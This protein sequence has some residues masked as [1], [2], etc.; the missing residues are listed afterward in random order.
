MPRIK[1]YKGNRAIIPVDTARVSTAYRCPF[2][3]AI[4]STKRQY[5]SHLKDLRKDKMH[6]AA[7]KARRRRLRNEFNNQPT[8]EKVIEWANNHPEFFF[9]NAAIHDPF[10]RLHKN[11]AQDRLEFEFEI[12]K[13]NLR[14]HPHVSNSHAA[15]YNGVKN[16][17]GRD[18]TLPT[19][20]PGW[21]GHISVKMSRIATFSS[22]VFDGTGINTGGGGG[23]GSGRYSYNVIFFDDDWPALAKRRERFSTM[24]SLG[25][26]AFEYFLYDNGR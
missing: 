14:W 15:P 1:A 21:Q 2:T 5:V 20:Y 8:F 11:Y 23:G 24:N 4:F 22:S 3:D 17:S 18:E 25:G 16:W 6:A 9:D 12:T 19:G 10:G 26:P 7:R 13:L